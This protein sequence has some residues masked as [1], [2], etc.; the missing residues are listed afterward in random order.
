MSAANALL[1]FA[2]CSDMMTFVDDRLVDFFSSSLRLFAVVTLITYDVCGRF[3][4]REGWPDVRS[5]LSGT[6]AVFA[7]SLLSWLSVGMDAVVLELCV[8]NHHKL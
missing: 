8:T 1:S 7:E 2:V 5:L 3:W 4:R 6:S